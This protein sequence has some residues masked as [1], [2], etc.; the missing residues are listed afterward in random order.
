MTA[1]AGLPFIAV[2]S[3]SKRFDPQ[4]SLGDR[5]A[6]ALG[7]AV[8]TRAV[9]AVQDVSL[10][11]ARGEVLGLVGESGCGK[12]TLGR[13]IAGI[14]PPTTGSVAIE[15]AP[16]MSGGRRPRKRTTRVQMIF[17]DPYAS[18]DPR[19][20]I[21]EALAEG[22]IAH[23][24][25]TRDDAAA[26]VASWLRKVGLDPD[27]AQR[28]PHQF[29]GGQRQRIAIAR[30]LAMRP[31][32]LV[33]DE[34][35]ASLDVSIQAQ[36]LNLFLELRRALSLTM[37]FISHHLG[38]VRHVSDRVA[39][40][41]LGRIVEIGPA[42]SIY[43]DPQHPYTRALLA[44][45]PQLALQDDAVATF[46]PI[47]GEL[48]SPLAPPPGCPFHQRCPLAQPRCRTQVPEMR[49]VGPQHA[50]ACHLL[51]AG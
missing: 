1:A 5:V 37:V 4:L 51:Q 14:L 36:V 16:V 6:G 22:P 3:V 13:M 35:V 9:R 38:V 24:L 48:P 25:S 12:S 39:I 44:S 23:R 20:R 33:C 21:G 41:Y 7:G 31:D 17:Q 28:Y 11:L 8:E 49:P 15:G 34:P 45:V 43:D 29:S 46:T 47:A 42:A 19:M 27:A 32:V 26:Y 18:L 40:M 30:A 50:A 10:Q 2:T